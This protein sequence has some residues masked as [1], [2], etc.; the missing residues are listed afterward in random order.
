MGTDK[1]K[2]LVGKLFTYVDCIEAVYFYTSEITVNVTVGLLIEIKGKE[3]LASG[4]LDSGLEVGG[5]G[6][7]RCLVWFCRD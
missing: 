4:R 1:T 5:P 7:F 6:K 2:K 3:V